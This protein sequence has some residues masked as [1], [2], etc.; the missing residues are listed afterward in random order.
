M[1]ALH[2]FLN[3]DGY[4]QTGQ[5]ML[6]KNMFAYC[7]NNPVNRLDSNGNSW[8]DIKNWVS[9][10]WNAVKSWVHNTF[11]TQ[12]MVS[13]KPSPLHYDRYG[14]GVSISNHVTVTNK[15]AK[16][17]TFFV[18]GTTN[19]NRKNPQPSFSGGIKLNTAKVSSTVCIGSNRIFM[20]QSLAVSVGY[21]DSNG[22]THTGSISL[23]PQNI[24][25]SGSVSSDI[26][27]YVTQTTST[28]IDISTIWLY[29]V[30][31]FGEAFGTA[32]FPNSSHYVPT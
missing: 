15:P 4:A 27:P 10:K 29:A 6:D 9:D 25:I 1:P 19:R 24:R 2:R 32:P 17:V 23:S 30:Y 21:K 18:H 8:A 20:P 3:A 31:A 7:G 12:M 26:S 13:D 22:I 14:V 5:G 28:D 11:G 16:P